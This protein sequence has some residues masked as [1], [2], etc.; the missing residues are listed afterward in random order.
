MIS[1]SN[2]AV[3][4]YKLIG[5]H[6]RPIRWTFEGKNGDLLSMVRK[7]KSFRE[8]T[9]KTIRRVIQNLIQWCKVKVNIAYK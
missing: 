1:L 9:Y 5:V 6:G 7:N 2:V 3:T 8:K 4:G